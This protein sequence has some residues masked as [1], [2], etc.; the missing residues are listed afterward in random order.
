MKQILHIKVGEPVETSLARARNSMQ[1]LQRGQTP[2]AYFGIGFADLPQLLSTFTPRRWELLKFLSEHGPMAVAELARALGRDYKNVH[3][4]IAALSEWM[5]VA[6]ELDG[7]VSV[8]WDE[9][10]LRLP[11]QHKAA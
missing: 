11:L 3:G 9:L 4:D 10:D 1:A 8:P 6:R 2:D 7:R 5:A